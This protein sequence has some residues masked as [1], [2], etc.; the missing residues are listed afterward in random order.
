[1]GQ[2]MT[3]EELHEFTVQTLMG[4][5][6]DT[7]AKVHRYDKQEPNQ[8][9]FYFVN[10]GRRPNFSLGISGEKKVNVMVVCR[11]KLTDRITDIDT[12]WMVS[13]YKRN[14]AITRGT[15]ATATCMYKGRLCN[16]M[17]D[18]VCGGDFCFE[19]YSVSLIP[20]L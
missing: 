12:T 3:A 15:F 9:D 7:N 14:G 18:S 4:E 11:E 1:M 20:D 5:Y 2:V 8:A 17:K 19:Y 13:E 6:F 16:K 10:T